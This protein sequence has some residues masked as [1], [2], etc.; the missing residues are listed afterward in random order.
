[1]TTLL[2]LCAIDPD[3]PDR[4]CVGQSRFLGDA[5]LAKAARG[6]DV[7]CAE[8]GADRGWRAVPGTWRAADVRD[9]GAVYAR[10][11]DAS[12]HVQR[13]WEARG[14]P[15][16]NPTGFSD[17]CADKL[18]WYRFARRAGLPVPET[19][20]ADDPTWRG[21]SRP[22][23]KPRRGRGGT[24]VR[25]LIRGD[26]PGPGVVQRAI[27]PR[28]RGESIRVL[29]QR[30]GARP[31]FQAGSLRRVAPPGEE[32]ASLARGATAEALTPAE[33][34]SLAPL[35]ARLSEALARRAEADRIL[36]VGVDVIWAAERPWLLEINARPGRSFDRAERPDQRRAALLHPFEAMLDLLA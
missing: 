34:R 8:P 4:R 2:V 22:Y 33:S 15:V 9:V 32:V 7:V 13:D 5:G 31:W 35:L 10:H 18:A 21:W 19:V 6:I 17:L 24:G 36:E 27:E 25:R 11:H 30:S 29:L 12:R 1:L 14:V 23:A 16:V 20:E 3:A 26:T 28:T